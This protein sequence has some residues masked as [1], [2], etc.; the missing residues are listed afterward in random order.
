M[1]TKRYYSINEA[2]SSILNKPSNIV[3]KEVKQKHTTLRYAY[4]DVINEQHQRQLLEEGVKEFL[5]KLS[6]TAK[7]KLLSIVTNPQYVKMFNITAPIV[8]NILQR[9]FQNLS[10]DDLTSFVKG[11]G[12]VIGGDASTMSPEQLSD[13]VSNLGVED[14]QKIE[15]FVSTEHHGDMTHAGDSVSHVAL[16]KAEGMHGQTTYDA[17]VQQQHAD[18]QNTYAVHGSRFQATGSNTQHTPLGQE[19]PAAHVQTFTKSVETLV[20]QAQGST[21]LISEF[22][23]LMVNIIKSDNIDG[24]GGSTLVEFSGSIKASSL[25]EAN[26]IA[27]ELVKAA[28][29]QSGIDLGNVKLAIPAVKESLNAAY[30]QVL[31]EAGFFNNAA[32]AVKNAAATVGNKV[33]AAAQAVGNKVKQMVVGA[34]AIADKVRQSFSKGANVPTRDFNVKVQATITAPVQA[35]APAQ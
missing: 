1:G 15:T 31:V 24:S 23:N 26:A 14:L 30:M 18:G 13:A 19:L 9:N 4:Q 21:D 27:Q 2:Y 12:H 17:G 20:T 3:N 32:N 28:I 35:A 22:K 11:L 6:A 7:N 10:M 29:K 5:S 33:Q 8:T 25:Q 16:D 34:K